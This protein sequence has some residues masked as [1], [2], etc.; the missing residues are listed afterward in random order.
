M[1]HVLAA[2]YPR[3]PYVPTTE[4]GTG[5][6]S[7]ITSSTLHSRPYCL[8]HSV[9]EQTYFIRETKRPDPTII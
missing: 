8:L 7:L 2:T 1:H 4:H 5:I 9:Q 3:E 6:F